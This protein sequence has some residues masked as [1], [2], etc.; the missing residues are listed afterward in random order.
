MLDKPVKRLYEA[1]KIHH[2]FSSGSVEESNLEARI[3]RGITNPAR[4]ARLGEFKHHVSVAYMWKSSKGY[5]TNECG[6]SII[7]ESWVLTA[8]HCFKKFKINRRILGRE[9]L[10]I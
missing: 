10:S 8:A 6:G 3:D 4:D 1:N 5:Q 9:W 7:H 2:K